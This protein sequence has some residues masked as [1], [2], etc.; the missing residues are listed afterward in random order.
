LKILIHWFLRQLLHWFLCIENTCPLVSYQPLPT[1]FSGEEISLVCGHLPLFEFLDVQF[2][3]VVLWHIN[4]FCHFYVYLSLFI[5]INFSTWGNVVVVWVSEESLC[6]S[7]F[8]YC[9]YIF[10]PF[11]LCWDLLPTQLVVQLWS[12]LFLGQVFDW[13]SYIY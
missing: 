9:L 11:Q 13:F 5:L 6:S 7:L 10:G 8:H 1:S 12:G 3:Y 4:F 2:N